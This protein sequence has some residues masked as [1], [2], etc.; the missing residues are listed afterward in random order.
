M[1][2]KIEATLEP[3]DTIVPSI[4]PPLCREIAVYLTAV[5]L[6]ILVFQNG[7][8]THNNRLLNIVKL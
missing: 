3:H 6:I 4:R 7:N 5:P 1:E 8:Y 2:A